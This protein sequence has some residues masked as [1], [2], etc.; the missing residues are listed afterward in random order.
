MANVLTLPYHHVNVLSGTKGARII[1][2]P[3]EYAM[4]IKK[5][6]RPLL[7][8]GPDALGRKLG[9]KLVLEWGLEIARVMNIPIVATAHTKKKI[10]E[11]GV[12]PAS[13]YDIIE[14]I[15]SLK[16]PD[17]MGVKKE[18]NHDLVLFLGIRTDLANAGLSTLKHFAP[19]LKTLTLCPY[20]FPHASYTM[21]NL[22]DAPWQEFLEKVIAELNVKEA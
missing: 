14:I 8:I 15:N 1:E 12:T 9:G 5:A 10:V 22:K 7:V 2:E 16:D 20:V 13:S 18:G 11:L 21:G 19:H 17:W 4:F 6:K 3:A